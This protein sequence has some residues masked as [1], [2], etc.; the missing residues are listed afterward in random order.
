MHFRNGAHCIYHTEYHIVWT[1]RYRRQIFVKGVDQYLTD[2]LMNL[3]GLDDDIEVIRVNVQIDHV[4][5]VTIIPPRLSVASAVQYM[6]SQSAK[7]LRE[8][9]EFIRKAISRGGIWSRGYCVSTV[10]MNEAMILK[11]VEHQERKDKGQLRLE[12]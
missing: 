12:L 9:F 11:Y 3:E 7:K 4:H 8:R 10:G 1:P 6:K 2:L 5:I